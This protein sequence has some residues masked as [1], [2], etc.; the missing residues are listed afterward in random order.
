[1][2]EAQIKTYD[3]EL[4][5]KV[6]RVEATSAYEAAYKAATYLAPGETLPKLGKITMALVQ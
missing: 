4:G 3:V 5:A 1:V 2:Y 6:I